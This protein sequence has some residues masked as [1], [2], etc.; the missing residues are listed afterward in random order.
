MNKDEILKRSRNENK[1]QDEME[2][3]VDAK[4]GRQAASI[5]LLVCMLLNL[6]ELLIKGQANLS[7]WIV[8]SVIMGTMELL[9]FSKL[10]KKADLISAVILLA[11]GVA[12]V[13]F[14]K[15]ELLN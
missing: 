1:G 12:F 10:R 8:W 14:Y 3:D 13:A 9:R 15:I 6:A 2:R 7:A 4:A 5:G 11:C